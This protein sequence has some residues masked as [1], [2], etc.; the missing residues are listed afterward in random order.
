VDRYHEC[1]AC[2]C[3]GGDEVQHWKIVD[4]AL[5]TYRDGERVNMCVFRSTLKSI[6]VFALE[7]GSNGSEQYRQESWTYSKGFNILE[8]IKS[9]AWHFG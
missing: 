5:Q 6:C 3:Q 2:Q 4:G 8:H 7:G 9:G 1:R